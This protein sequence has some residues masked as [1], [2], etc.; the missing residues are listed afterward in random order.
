MADITDELFFFAWQAT[1][2]IRRYASHLLFRVILDC[3]PGK[4]KSS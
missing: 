2:P 1:S 4:T 3:Q